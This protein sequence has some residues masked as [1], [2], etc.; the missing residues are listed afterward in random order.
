MMKRKSNNKRD[1]SK[2]MKKTTEPN[3]K[4]LGFDFSIN[5]D[6]V[7]SCSRQLLPGIMI[8]KYKTHC[9][10]LKR[11]GRT[12]KDRD[13][14]ERIVKDTI[15][16]C[17]TEISRSLAHYGSLQQKIEYGAYVIIKMK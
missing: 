5:S 12:L 7:F 13:K 4:Y 9:L 1:K 15:K 10:V 11:D 2:T 14:I 6:A 3:I 17:P 16:H 8:G